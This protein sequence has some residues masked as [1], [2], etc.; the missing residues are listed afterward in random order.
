M[1]GDAIGMRVQFGVVGLMMTGSTMTFG[2]RR[3]DRRGGG[4]L[5]GIGGTV[6]GVLARVVRMWLRGCCLRYLGSVGLVVVVTVGW[7][8]L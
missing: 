7:A 1:F 5:V 6:P 2:L 4:S 8:T 3:F